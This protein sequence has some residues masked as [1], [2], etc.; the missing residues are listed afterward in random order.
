MDMRP[1]P[2][3]PA[4]TPAVIDWIL[5]GL[6]D[7]GIV[8]RSSLIGCVAFIL[9]GCATT[10]ASTGSGK[11]AGEF[12][13]PDELKQQAPPA[14]IF[15]GGTRP[16]DRWVLTG[17]LPARVELAAHREESPWQRQLEAAGAKR[18]GLVFLSEQMHCVARETGL[19]LLANKAS[20]DP[21]LDR[22]IHSRCGA[23]TGAS[24][25]AWISGD[26]RPEETDEAAARRMQDGLSQ[27]LAKSLSS[28]NL[29]AGIWFGRKENQ[30]V[31]MVS[32]ETR[33]AQLE[34]VEVRP[35][36]TGQVII[37]GEALMAAGSVSG[38]I[39][40]G[41]FGVEDCVP[42]HNVALPKFSFACPADPSDASVSLELLG[43][44]PGR[45]LGS[46][47]VHLILWPPAG[48]PKVYVHSRTAAAIGDGSVLSLVNQVRANANLALL[49]IAPRESATA[50]SLAPI[51]FAALT[52]HAP[53]THADAIAL[54]LL[55]GWEVDGI[56]RDGRIASAWLSSEA[57][58]DKLI[59]EL[60][61][62]PSGRRTLLAPDARQVAIGQ[63][64]KG[65]ASAAVV[66][67]YAFFEARDY[68]AEEM[69]VLSRIA[70]ERAARQRPEPKMIAGLRDQAR[71]S[72]GLVQSG[73]SRPEEALNALAQAASRG[74][75]RQVHTWGMES[76][77]LD[78]V[79][80]PDGVLDS[81]S[82]ALGI[83]IGHYRPA[84][85]A[86]GR[87]VVFL[88]MIDAPD[89]I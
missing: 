40:H 22:F 32:W 65:A 66:T 44:P 41:R 15:G 58:E 1:P 61:D 84:G 89:S 38:V 78:E 83:A 20:P 79:Q 57:G 14:E 55:A 48:D 69:R 5:Q 2:A 50:A 60:L 27:L 19:F 29:E 59:E 21:S 17:P 6:S 86:W 35:G 82:A 8:V 42:D 28:G 9:S 43:T 72:A 80:L 3:S 88:V 75:T 16:V 39:T 7:G 34:P 70:K 25:N 62:L 51:Y 73:Q 37:R 56:V 76:V 68:T 31:A 24:A 45:V 46:D 13:S 77:S 85:A 33:L 74:G 54:G 30:L 47:L 49:S 11:V 36:A 87:Y 4:L 71:K 23:V 52:G 12:T 81:K 26:T 10:G 53:E 63:V 64:K 18:P 67:T